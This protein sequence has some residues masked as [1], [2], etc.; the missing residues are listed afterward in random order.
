MERLT[1]YF[2]SPVFR[3]VLF[4][5]VVY[6]YFVL[7]VNNTSMY[8]SYR[9]ILESFGLIVLAQIIIAYMSIYILIPR[10]LDKNRIGLFA[11][12]M[13][14]LLMAVFALYQAAK[15]FYFDVIYFDSYNEIQVKY[16]LEPYG[17]RL[18]YFSVFLSKCILYLTPT[19]LL[20]MA[21]FYQ[22]QQ[23]F[24]KLNEQ[25]KTAELTALRNQ[26]NP[27]FL[28]NTLNNLY[29]L[30]LDK[31]DKTPEVIEKL[32]DIL[33][34]IL[35]RCKNNYVHVQKEIDLIE[36][37]L[38]LEKIRYDK[39]VSVSFDHVIEPETKI[40]PLL[41]LTFV[42]NAFKHGVTQELGMAKIDISL[43]ANSTSILFS[44]QNSKPN[45]AIVEKSNGDGEPLG[46]KNVMQQLELLYPNSHALTLTNEEDAYKA[47]LRLKRK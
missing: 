44:I 31:S 34:Y 20:L 12:W 28:F 39:R 15:T 32:S 23:K 4:W 43:T 26:L 22:N 29:S 35:Y 1:L 46:L 21:R 30:A 40:A 19:A 38:A 27:H 5:T 18:T 2:K 13:L 24:L 16:A 36:N 14:I 47:V 41:L 17:K 11:F 3:H 42:E 33:D 10:L 25:K 9:H 7:S 45:T 6:L 8:A 37:Y